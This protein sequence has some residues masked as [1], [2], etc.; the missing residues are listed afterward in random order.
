MN[1]AEVRRL[2]TEPEGEHIEFKPS[3]PTRQEVADYAVGIS[4][5]GGGALLAGVSDRRP[6]RIVAFRMPSTSDLAKI[7]DSVLDS[8]QLHVTVES[9]PTSDGP[10]LAISIPPHPRGIPVSTKR[11][12]YLIRVGE[13]LRGMT[14]EQI[15]AIRREAGQ[16]LT[17]TSIPAPLAALV[18]AA[19]VEELRQLMREAG[20]PD[21]LVRQRDADLLRGLNVLDSGG[22]LKIAGLILV[23]Q[24]DALRVHV[25]H[26]QWQFRRMTSDTAYDQAEDGVDSIA[27][28]LRRLRDLIGANN[29][30]VTIPGWLV[31]PEFP[32]YPRLA[33]RELLINAFVHRDYSAP[34][35]VTV[36]VHPH[37][38][39]IS[40]PGGFVG[41]ITPKN[42]LHHPSSP[43]Y[44][45]L[46]TALVQMRLANATNLGVPRAFRELLNEGKE[47][48][49][50]WTSGHAVRVTIKG[51]E[52]R[53][54]FLEFVRSHPGLD[55]DHLLLI[56]AL[57]RVREMTARQAATLCQRSLEE[58]RELLGEL[59]SR[60]RVLE[61]GGRGTGRYYRF[62]RDA[63]RVLGNALAYH[64]DRPLREA[65]ARA[66]VL[67]VLDER[68]LTNSDVREITQLT[69]KQVVKL[70]KELEAGGFVRLEGQKRGSRW[71]RVHPASH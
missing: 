4:N 58:A 41:T 54:G 39:E 6:R 17:A 13:S 49:I 47:P 28:A 5:A 16:E 32:R 65:N 31:H 9:V 36:K 18:S 10:V 20:A 67:E 64:V 44:P 66:R 59:A 26:A 1:E 69:R 7:R 34:G 15:D 8:A 55:V 24:S 53:R 68:E 62:S 70:M 57:T 29:P 50:Y 42:I 25:P 63:D 40:N 33:L 56:H 71:V 3:V 30:I 46:M 22:R 11:G 45:A 14:I 27:V 48:P 38:L 51:Q 12:H 35:A 60:F 19:A 52:A 37:K 43:R 61:S 23:G 2:M 21:D